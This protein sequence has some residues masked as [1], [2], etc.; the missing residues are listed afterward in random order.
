MSESTCSSLT[1]YINPSIR[2]NAPVPKHDLIK[3]DEI[4]RN[5]GVPRCGAIRSLLR[6]ALL[7]YPV[8]RGRVKMV[9]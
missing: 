5:G 4:A 2:Q 9:R 3:H 7:S 6:R 8:H 1:T